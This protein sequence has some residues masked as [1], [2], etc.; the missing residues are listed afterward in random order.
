MPDEWANWKATW[1][2]LKSVYGITHGDVDM[3]SAEEISMKTDDVAPLRF[4]IM[5]HFINF[6]FIITGNAIGYDVNAIL[7]FAQV[8]T[9]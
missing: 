1:N 8:V 7:C 5:Q 6:L 3:S 9:A 2:D 4:V